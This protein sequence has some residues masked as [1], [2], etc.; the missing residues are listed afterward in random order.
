MEEIQ[1]ERKTENEFLEMARDCAV[2]ID[3]K[4][5]EI[6][7]IKEKLRYNRKKIIHL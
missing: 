5:K 6:H 7:D 1:L 4:N 3:E 2:R